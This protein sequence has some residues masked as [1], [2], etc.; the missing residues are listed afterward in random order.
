MSIWLGN[1]YTSIGSITDEKVRA[2][3]RL[4]E[5]SVFIKGYVIVPEVYLYIFDALPI[6]CCTLS[7]SIVLPWQLNYSKAV[8]DVFDKWEWGILLPIAW[9][10]RSFIRR[11][12]EKREAKGQETA[13][14]PSD[15]PSTHELDEL[16]EPP[17]Q[18][19]TL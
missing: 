17:K 13:R 16:N 3:F 8:G 4:V 1:L 12:K 11:R 7:F 2:I 14:S 5:F 15:N 6:L 19:V 18:I 10:I 9:P